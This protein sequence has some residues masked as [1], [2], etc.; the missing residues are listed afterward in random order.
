M[1]DLAFA[2]HPDMHML[3]DSDAFSLVRLLA[4]YAPGIPSAVSIP[5]HGFEIVD[6]QAGKQ[7]YLD[8]AW[9]EFFQQ[10]WRAW[11][12]KNSTQED[13]DTL[14]EQYAQLAQNPVQLH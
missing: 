2:E 14:L 11:E 7:V 9:A 3:Y 12:Y 10:A 6:K 5:R 8:G 13:L 1:H 4:Q